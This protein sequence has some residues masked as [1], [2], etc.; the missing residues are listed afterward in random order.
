MERGRILKKKENENRERGVSDLE[1]KTQRENQKE[2]G[3]GKEE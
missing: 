1:K 2:I 3:E